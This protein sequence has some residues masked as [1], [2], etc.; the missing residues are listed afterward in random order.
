M[1]MRRL[2]AVFAAVVLWSLWVLCILLILPVLL[3]V[4][5]EATPG[6][7]ALWLA[8][9]CAVVTYPIVLPVLAVVKAWAVR[10]SKPT[11]LAAIHTV[12]WGAFVGVM[13]I[14]AT[15]AGAFYAH[16]QA[17]PVLTREEG[18]TNSYANA[19]LRQ[20]TTW[21]DRILKEGADV[22]HPMSLGSTP[23]SMSAGFGDWSLV[24]FL[25]GHGADPDRKDDQGRSVRTLAAKP[26]ALPRN[27][28]EAYALDG[29]RKLLSKR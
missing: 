2:I 16:E 21:M 4:P 29:V 9:L 6:E 24:L 3:N 15:L 11:I 8:V 1:L 17:R 25:L 28:T 5:G 27:A 23:A 14:L 22:D 20:D 13:A 7:I 18:F 10:K 12:T 19:I 26:P